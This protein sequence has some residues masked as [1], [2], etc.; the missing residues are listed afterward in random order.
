MVSWHFRMRH[1]IQL[2]LPAIVLLYLA[3]LKAHDI[4]LR[5]IKRLA[6]KA[7]LARP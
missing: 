1:L 7:I 2:L 4:F 5:F 3:S 6:G